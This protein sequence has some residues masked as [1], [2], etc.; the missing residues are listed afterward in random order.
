MSTEKEMRK[1]IKELKR[2]IEELKIR[3]KLY[4]ER[5]ENAHDKN[6]KLRH[7]KI[8]MTVDDVVVMQKARAEYEAEHIRDK[9]F[10]DALDKQEEVKIDGAL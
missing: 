7:E 9:E 8:H 10:A 1:E 2:E 3:E 5:L 4:L 6:H